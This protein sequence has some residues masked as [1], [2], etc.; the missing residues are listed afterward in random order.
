M[1][2]IE[3]ETGTVSK[4]PVRILLEHFIVLVAE[5]HVNTLQQVYIFPAD[6]LHD[7]D[8]VN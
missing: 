4:W 7:L 6:H 3:T 5:I 1:V 8:L 2:A